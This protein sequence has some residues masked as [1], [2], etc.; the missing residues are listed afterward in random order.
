MELNIEQLNSL[1]FIVA[2]E[3]RKNGESING[4]LSELREETGMSHVTKE[5]GKVYQVNFVHDYINRPT[6]NLVWYSIHPS[7]SINNV[8]VYP[9]KSVQGIILHKGEVF[10][11]ELENYFSDLK[12]FSRKVEKIQGYLE[13]ISLGV[14]EEGNRNA[15]SWIIDPIKF[16]SS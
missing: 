10:L 9:H 6:S 3:L 14:E 7:E 15:A 1:S 5:G 2:E 13:S 16:F 12:N 11:S 8:V 4:I